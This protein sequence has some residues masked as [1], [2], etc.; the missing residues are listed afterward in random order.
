[1]KQLFIVCMVLS[2]GLLTACSPQPIKT[3]GSSKY[4]VQIQDNGEEYT[5][6]DNTRYKYK[7]QG[8]NEDG[9][10]KKFTFTANHQLKQDA[11]LR[12]YSKK[13]EVITYEEVDYDDIPKE[14]QQLL[15]DGN[16]S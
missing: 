3:I 8:F 14:A 12:I 1:M 16:N 9:E 15:E 11:Y 4:Y 5:E 6:Q 2:I 13:D 7:L 10:G